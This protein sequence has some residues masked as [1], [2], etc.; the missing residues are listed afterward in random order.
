MK[1]RSPFHRPTER[2]GGPMRRRLLALLA[3]LLALA[4][5]ALPEGEAASYMI[6]HLEKK[7]D[8]KQWPLRCVLCDALAATPGPEVTK[9]LSSRLDDKVPY[10]TS[11]AAKALGKRKDKASVDALIKRL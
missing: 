4:L 5:A 2:S 3:A 6:E 8:P 10:V 1:V 7:T 9:A 11:A